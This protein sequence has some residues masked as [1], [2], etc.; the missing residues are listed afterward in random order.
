MGALT[1]P[2]GLVHQVAPEPA[3]D[4]AS[5]GLGT[6]WVS[7]QT[8]A[9]PYPFGFVA[10]AAVDAARELGSATSARQLDVYV[11]S[12][13][14]QLGGN[15]YPS[16]ANEAIVS[17]PYLVARTL[18]DPRSA[19]APIPPKFSVAPEVKNLMDRIVLHADPSLPDGTARIV[20][21]GGTRAVSC[22]AARGTAGHELTASETVDKFRAICGLEDPGPVVTAVM[23]E[24][25]S[26]RHVID[27][28]R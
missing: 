26:L 27:L 25:A 11:S 23:D 22:A 19:Q 15:A 1:G 24:N 2:N 12:R 18:A 10:F 14:E 21:D 5:M 13:A 9:K 20:V 6:D 4:K 8:S 17:I 16:D 28:L 7:T 3:L